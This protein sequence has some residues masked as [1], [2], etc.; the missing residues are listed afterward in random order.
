MT[1]RPVYVSMDVETLGVVPGLH[2]LLSVG[3]AAFLP[4]SVSPLETFQ[5]CLK[6]RPEE[7]IHEDTLD[8]W[9]TQSVEAIKVSTSNP[10]PPKEV[11]HDLDEWIAGVEC[12]ANRTAVI[13]TWRSFDQWW[14]HHLLFTELGRTD[15]LKD[16]IDIR[17]FILPLSGVEPTELA[18]RS[19]P[20]FLRREDVGDHTAI[21]DAVAQGRWFMRALASYDGTVAWGE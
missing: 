11:A 17:S 7:R 18:T 2:P 4:Y 8:W 16:A 5:R 14:L 6:A 1:A 3:A 21:G 19:I 12:R 20:D 15:R 13:V 10:R 9:M